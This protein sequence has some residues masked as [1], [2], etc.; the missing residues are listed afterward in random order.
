MQLIEKVAQSKFHIVFSIKFPD[1]LTMDALTNALNTPTTFSTTPESGADSGVLVIWGYISCI[2]AV[3]FFGSNWVPVKK[4]ET[5]DGD[6]TIRSYTLH[7]FVYNFKI[8][9][10]THSTIQRVKCKSSRF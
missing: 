4:F 6:L 7:C 10:L 2:I 5:G 9:I 3:L 1:L 8:L